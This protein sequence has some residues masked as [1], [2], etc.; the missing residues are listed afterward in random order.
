MLL[1]FC[2]F[3]LGALDQVC[4]L[5]PGACARKFT[6][7]FGRW[8]VALCDTFGGGDVVLEGPKDPQDIAS[9]ESDFELFWSHCVEEREDGSCSLA[10]DKWQDASCK[11]KKHSAFFL[12]HFGMFGI[13][14]HWMIS[15]RI[16][17]GAPLFAWIQYC[18]R[19]LTRKL[20]AGIGASNF[21]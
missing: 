3:G 15:G 4:L 8:L 11:S 20:A 13:S 6:A 17:Q 18:E 10:G 7:E 16:D 21:Q 5:E 1:L 2:V 19:F 12:L 9:T 14:C